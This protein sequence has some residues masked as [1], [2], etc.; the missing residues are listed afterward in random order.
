ME[1][2]KGVA[3]GRRAQ[4]IQAGNVGGSVIQAQ[5]DVFLGKPPR[6]EQYEIVQNWDRQ[7]RLREFDLSNRDLSGLDLSGADLTN[8]NLSRATLDNAKLSKARLSHADLS[9]AFLSNAYLEDADLSSANLYDAFLAWARLASAK[10]DFADLRKVAGTGANLWKASMLHAKMTEAEFDLEASLR[11]ADLRWAE[12]S[13]AD[14]SNSDLRQADLSRANLSDANLTGTDLRQANLFKADL[15]G[16][17]LSYA[18]LREANLKGANLEGA[19]YD[20]HTKWPE[21][22]T[23]AESPAQYE[24][25]QV[26]E[27]HLREAT[28]L[29]QAELNA[30]DRIASALSGMSQS[31]STG[32]SIY[33]GSFLLTVSYIEE[34]VLDAHFGYLDEDLKQQ[35]LNSRAF[36][37]ELGWELEQDED[38]EY[39]DLEISVE[40]E[41]SDDREYHVLT[42]NIV[43]IM[44][45][46][47]GCSANDLE[48]DV[49]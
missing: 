34:R 18:D 40:F 23:P 24:R 6:D 22:F 7:R 17:D 41:A 33:C 47:F 8:A 49:F 12:M 15:S 28:G 37:E 43:A 10:L 35:A 9:G 36:I 19:V 32:A 16:A 4:A 14:L 5:G 3:F 42:N 1:D 48:I 21:G 44:T 29:S 27:F 11:H 2:V 45:R 46:V 20:F 31:S 39:E 25:L 30:I 26:S 13:K 38:D